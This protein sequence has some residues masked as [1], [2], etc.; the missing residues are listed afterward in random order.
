MSSCRWPSLLHATSN[1]HK[2]CHFANA[3]QT[4]DFQIVRHCLEPTANPIFGCAGPSG[5][6]QDVQLLPGTT[7]QQSNSLIQGG[8]FSDAMTCGA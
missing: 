5:D 8:Q 7:R 4:L 6:N 1:T 2:E 3:I